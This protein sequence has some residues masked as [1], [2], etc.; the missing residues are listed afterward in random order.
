MSQ[1]V[2]FASDND[3]DTRALPETEALWYLSM[4]SKEHRTLLK[5][6]V[7]ASFLWLKWQRIRTFWFSN[8][9]LYVAFV[10]FLTTFVFMRFGGTQLQINTS[11][12]LPDMMSASEGEGVMAKRP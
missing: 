10:A 2:E 9:I 3:D 6:P 7:I 12:E 8:L 1:A 11:R 5:H 4:A